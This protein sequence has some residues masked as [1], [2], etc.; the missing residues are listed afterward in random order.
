MMSKKKIPKG[1]KIH[2]IQ[3]TALN[4]V[5]HGLHLTTVTRVIGCQV[6]L[7]YGN[8]NTQSAYKQEI[9]CSLLAL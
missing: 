7:Q 9:M 1:L 6:P 4:N 3:S 8:D 5:C 2:I